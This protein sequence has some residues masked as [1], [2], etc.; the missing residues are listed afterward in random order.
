MAQHPTRVLSLFSGIGGLDRG[1]RLALPDAEWVA[2]VERESFACGIL[3]ARVSD[4]SLAPAHV[5]AGDV[6]EFPAGDLRGR[7]DLVTAGFPCPP[8]S[9]A[10]KRRGTADERWLWP[11]VAR[12]LRETGAGWVLLENVAG[13][14]SANDG[15]AFRE[16][17]ADLAGLGFDVEWTS[18]RA[19]D[20]GAPHRRERVFLLGRRRGVADPLGGA[21]QRR[22]G[23]GPVGE[24]PVGAP[25]ETRQR[26]GGDPARG[27]VGPV[28]ERGLPDLADAEDEAGAHVPPARGGRAASEHGD[29]DGRDAGP[30]GP[31]HW[32]PGPSERD[33]WRRILALW[34]ELAPATVE[35][36]EVESGLRGVARG[37]AR[38]LDRLRALGNIVV[39][40]QAE[41][42]LRILY[43]RLTGE[44]L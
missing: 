29:A 11:Q 33:E 12:V 15:G 34:P 41:L 17:L 32:P 4:G 14:L 24:A 1:V 8:V 40:E 9:H 39:P 22:G 7:I 36:P 6:R 10:G 2:Y 5:F 26:R 37:G 19:S 30:P 21:V 13:L 18:V 44:D 35:S 20:V 31:P 28:H 43:A 3:A 42:A 25:G 23:P 27:A 16:I 38:R